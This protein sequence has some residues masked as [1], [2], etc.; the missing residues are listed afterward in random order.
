MTD[1][2][3]LDL[4]AIDT[5]IAAAT[6]GPWGVYEY[7]GDS[8]IEIAADL[9]D[10]G[11]GYSARRTV[12]RLDEEPLDND[13]AHRG[14]MAEEDWAQVQADARFIAAMSPE[15]VKAMAAEI[16]RLRAELAAARAAALR[17]AADIADG[18]RQFERTTGPRAAA[19][20]SENVG[21]LRVANELR[22]RAEASAA[23]ETHVVA[24]DSDDEGLTGPCDCGEGAVHY[25]LANCPA[26]Q[27]GARP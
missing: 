26:A 1:P 12:C 5:V 6:P 27:R 11:T 16:R 24:D 18:L 20:I 15:T 22:R 23:V 19:Q 9:E 17:E 10:T 2:Q 8:L 4:D 7:G 25:T 21:I 13:P 14:W 3:P